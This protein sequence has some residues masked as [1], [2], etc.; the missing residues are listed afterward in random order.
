M[1]GPKTATVTYAPA[2]DGLALSGLVVAALALREVRAIAD[3]TAAV[4]AQAAERADER[5]A[6]RQRQAEA[7]AAR[8]IECRAAALA[9]H[10]ELASQFE[11]LTRLVPDAQLPPLPQLPADTADADTWQ[12]CLVAA[13][14]ARAELATHLDQLA[15]SEA[16]SDR[17]L[18]D[19]PDIPDL[20]TT[21]RAWLLER[22]RQP[23]L[24][25]VESEWY[26][27]TAA[28]ILARLERDLL[29]VVPPAL[30]E[31]AR[32]IVLAPDRDRA[33]ALASELRLK[34]Q[35]A[36]DNARAERQRAEH[37]AAAFVLET[38]L[39]D[40]GYAVEDIGETLFVEGG[41]V[42]FQKR[43]WGGHFVRL[44]I[45]SQRGTANFNV[46]RAGAPSEGDQRR[47]DHLAEDRWC[48]EMPRL[49]ETLRSRGLNLDLQ[50]HIAAGQLPVQ[51][52]DASSLPRL[53]TAEETTVRRKQELARPI[54]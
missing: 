24:S 10:G 48:A 47:A 51:V 37:E 53:V 42:H 7:V 22:R 8:R 28:R 32:A 15:A 30:A 21:L 36:N 31:L 9:A 5:E 20:D 2:I 54:R 26:A 46:V 6:L 14:A 11:T 43:G 38:S 18:A 50:R 52:V 17:T 12:D 40:L 39:R 44:R 27:A 23:A 35:A 4:N 33:E 1:S 29:P 25:A 3:E 19:L 49:F 45:D 34:V 41:I 16:A 13:Q